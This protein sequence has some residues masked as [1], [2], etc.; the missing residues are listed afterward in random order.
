MYVTTPKIFHTRTMVGFRSSIFPPLSLLFTFFTCL[1]AHMARNQNKTSEYCW[2]LKQLIAH[3]V[4]IKYSL[5]IVMYTIYIIYYNT[6]HTQAY[7]LKFLHDS[8]HAHPDWSSTAFKFLLFL[9]ITGRC[10]ADQNVAMVDQYQQYKFTLN[11]I[12]QVVRFYFTISPAQCVLFL[13]EQHVPKHLFFLS[14]NSFPAL[15][16]FVYINE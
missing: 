9:Y 15:A 3:N 10:Y 14:H 1:F 7:Y 13:T 11:Q 12:C 8:I 2:N 16:R 5:L 4:G 6:Y